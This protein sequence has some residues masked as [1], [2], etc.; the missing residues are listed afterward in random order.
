[1]RM[2]LTAAGRQMYEEYKASVPAGQ[3]VKPVYEGV[4][5]SM[6]YAVAHLEYEGSETYA[7]LTDERKATGLAQ[8]LDRK[9]MLTPR[10]YEGYWTVDRFWL[11]DDLDEARRPSEMIYPDADDYDKY[12]EVVS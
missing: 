6:V 4:M 1:M 8:L 7:V 10:G 9:E 11:F 3:P 2:R 5:P 12:W